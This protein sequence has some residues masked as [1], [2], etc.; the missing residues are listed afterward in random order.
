MFLIS[1]DNC[2]EVQSVKTFEPLV[3]EGKELDYHESVIEKGFKS[4]GKAAIHV[5]ETCYEIVSSFLAIRDQELYKKSHKTFGD[6]CA[7]RWQRDP[8]TIQYKMESYAVLAFLCKKK[9]TASFE[10][11]RTLRKLSKLENNDVLWVVRYAQ[12]Q[13]KSSGSVIPTS[14][15]TEGLAELRKRNSENAV[16]KN[17]TVAETRLPYA[18]E[19]EVDL[20][21]ISLTDEEISGAIR[22]PENSDDLMSANDRLSSRAA[23]VVVSNGA[24]DHKTVTGKIQKLVADYG[25]VL[26]CRV[27][28]E[29][30]VVK[31]REVVREVVVDP[32]ALET[33][34]DV[35]AA[36]REVVERCSSPI[37]RGAGVAMWLKSC[38]LRVV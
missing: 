31:A 35:A 28:H 2:V 1:D 16:E 14:K 11:E 23:G 29:Q 6:Y 26:V 20:S 4:L 33:R 13:C 22:E 24:G 37:E 25:D 27:L 19:A 30:N 21:E 36:L 5:S 12:K 7:D 15:I 38:G 3:A 10:S 9:I 34:E 32:P 17:T 8:R 18:D